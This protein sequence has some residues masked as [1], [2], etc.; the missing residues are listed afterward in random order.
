MFGWLLGILF[1]VSRADAYLESVAAELRRL[2]MSNLRIFEKLRLGQLSRM[3]PATIAPW[4]KV[5]I[6]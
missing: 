5:R 4:S 1:D 3:A 2:Q 6:R